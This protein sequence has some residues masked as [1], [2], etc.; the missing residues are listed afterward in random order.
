MPFLLKVS[1]HDRKIR[2]VLWTIRI[3]LN[4]MCNRAIV[5][6]SF[7]TRIP[8]RR[9]YPLHKLRIVPAH[10]SLLIPNRS[11]VFA[12][13][14]RS[15]ISDALNILPEAIEAVMDVTTV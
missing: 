10:D 3:P 8:L 9:I 12:S 2:R 6:Q 5:T 11:R 4:R 13:R 1:R 7:V 14:H 15:V